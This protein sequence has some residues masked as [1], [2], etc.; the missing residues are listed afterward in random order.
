LLLCK[1][2]GAGSLEDRLARG[3][4]PAVLVDFIVQK[5]EDAIWFLLFSQ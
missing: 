4:D 2:R 1:R 5:E 3:T